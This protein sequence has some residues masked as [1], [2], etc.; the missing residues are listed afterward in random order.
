MVCINFIKFQKQQVCLQ[1]PE[2]TFTVDSNA[3][4]EDATAKDP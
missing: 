2:D 1:F 3:L 4:Y